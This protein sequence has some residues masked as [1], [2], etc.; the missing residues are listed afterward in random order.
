RAAGAVGARVRGRLGRGLHSG[1]RRCAERRRRLGGVAHT[2]DRRADPD[3]AVGVSAWF[4]RWALAVASR[5]RVE[6]DLGHSQVGHWRADLQ[7][8]GWHTASMPRLSTSWTNTW[9]SL[10][11]LLALS[12]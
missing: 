11:C 12:C 5:G 6:A 2:I 3:D 10:L 1:G 7:R 9:P 4:L 8:Q